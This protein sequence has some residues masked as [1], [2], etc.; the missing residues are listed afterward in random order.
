MLHVTVV[1]G[2]NLPWGYNQDLLRG[3]D[4]Y[5]YVCVFLMPGTD[6]DK[7]T[8]LVRHD[9]DSNPTYNQEF[10][11]VVGRYLFLIIRFCSCLFQL[12]PTDVQEKT[13]VFQVWGSR[14]DNGIGEVR[15]AI[16]KT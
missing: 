13:I 5:Y 6:A 7:R 4:G 2:K 1:Q 11:Y 10:S 12:S 3:Y 14:W 9:Y 15:N 8:E 16:S